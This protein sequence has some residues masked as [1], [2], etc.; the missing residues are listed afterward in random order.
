MSRRRSLLVLA[1]LAT[2]NAHAGNPELA[3]LAREDQASRMAAQQ[4]HRDAER[5]QHVLRILASG[6][7]L[8]PTDKL[9]AALAE[10]VADG[11]YKKINDKYFPFSIY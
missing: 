5:R 11:T 8:D 7:A 9:N 1:I 10:I 3:Q 4:D 2:A 6:Q